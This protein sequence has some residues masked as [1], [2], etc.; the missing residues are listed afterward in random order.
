[1][2]QKVAVARAR[3]RDP[4]LLLLDEPTTGL[5]AVA[6]GAVDDMM[7]SASRQGRTLVIATHHDVTPGLSARVVTLRD[8]SVEAGA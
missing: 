7:L 4:E 5:D 8:G 3:V 6:K 2:R 1:M